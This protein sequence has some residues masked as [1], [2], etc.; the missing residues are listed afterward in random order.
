MLR[1][2]GGRYLVDDGTDV[3]LHD[4]A[5]DCASCSANFYIDGTEPLQP[6]LAR[7]LHRLRSRHFQ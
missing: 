4:S 2:L 3:L 6:R 5:D 7:R 1:L